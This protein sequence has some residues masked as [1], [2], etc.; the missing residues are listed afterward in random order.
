MMKW[1]ILGCVLALVFY[2]IWPFL[3]IRSYS[4]WLFFGG[5]FLL[6][7]CILPRLTMNKNNH[8]GS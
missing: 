5:I 6:V 7:F 8:E 2:F 1:M 3:D 4:D